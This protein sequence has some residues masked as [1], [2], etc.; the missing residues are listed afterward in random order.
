MPSLPS[1][2][3]A[4]PTT[5]DRRWHI[6]SV[7]CL[8]LMLVMVGNISLNVALPTLARDLN[9]T[10]A[11]LQWIVDAYGLVFAGLLFAA[12]A[13]GDR[14]GRKGALQFGLAVVLCGSV[15]AST[16]QGAALIIGSRAV[17]GLGAAFVMPSTLSLLTNVFPPAERGRAIAIWA[18]VASGGAALG[19]A[20][21]GG[22]LERF[23]W[24]AVFLVNV[25]II[26]AALIAGWF[27]VPTS[28][29]PEGHPLDLPGAV[30]STVA[31]SSLLYAI[32]EAPVHG[33]LSPSTLG[34]FALAVLFLGLFAAR[35]ATAK[36]PMLDLRLFR[37]R[38]FS[39]ASF[40]IAL[41]FFTMFGT[42]F[43]LAQLLQLV[44]G[45]TPLEAGLMQLPFSF[46][47]MVVAPQVPRFVESYGSHVVGAVGL[48]L[49]AIST[50]IFAMATPSSG[51]AFLL[52][53]AVIGA[54]GM[55]AV[56]TPLTTL[57]M[58]SVPPGRA[59][60]GSAVNDTTRELGGA[61]GVA[62]LGSIMASGYATSVAPA[63]AGLGIEDRATAIA[64][65]PGAVSVAIKTGDEA[66]R[67]AAQIAFLHGLRTAYLAAAALMA[68]GAVAAW[69]LLPRTR[70]EMHAPPSRFHNH[71]DEEPG[72]LT[73]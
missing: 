1:S 64:S 13:I 22:L 7:L 6:L 2:L 23:S 73:D 26:V 57:I 12:G 51:I 31:M 61:L 16:A 70:A 15:L 68:V 10:P 47:V 17:M 72:P 36:D 3:P 34:V 19:P 46:V 71:F 42:F 49:I 28:K 32:I 20:I 41:T 58:A 43:L 48:A 35:Q 65:L 69:F 56:P 11:A 54:L 38:R 37:D 59:G 9:A 29:D 62:A 45:F 63:L 67:H 52:T 44:V 55:A 5:Y 18:A 30:L 27:I 21:A 24:H 40:G 53:A 60:V 14:F 25:P 8:S 33:W 66:L 4:D 50:A 39:V